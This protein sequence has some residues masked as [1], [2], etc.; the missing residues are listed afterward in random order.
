MS[1]AAVSREHARN[2]ATS[3]HV[4]VPVPWERALTIRERLLE[5]GIKS[6]ARF[7][8]QGQKAKLEILHD[9]DPHRVKALLRD[10]PK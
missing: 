10:V 4:F 1:M 9:I 7:D 6:I 3:R 2:A 8:P 5:W